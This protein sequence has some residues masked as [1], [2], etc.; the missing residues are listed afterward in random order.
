ML[1][2][3]DPQQF[4]D[5]RKAV[6]HAYWPE[7]AY[8]AQKSQ[9]PGSWSIGKH[10]DD[11]IETLKM[12]LFGKS[13]DDPLAIVEQV[14][15]SGKFY[16][17][18]NGAAKTK[19]VGCPFLGRFHRMYLK[20]WWTQPY[21][22]PQ[23]QAE[24]LFR[25]ER[26]KDGGNYSANK[27]NFYHFVNVVSALARLIIY[28]KNANNITGL[29]GNVEEFTS[30][31]FGGEP[32]LR[33]FKLMLAGFYHDIGKTVADPR[34]AVEGAIILG[35]HTTSA[36][37]QLHEIVG[38]YR[39]DY[40]FER[41]DLLYVAALVLYHDHFGTLGTGEDGYMALVNPEPKIILVDSTS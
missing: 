40:S 41:E 12:C 32:S 4:T 25:L 22:N 8:L 9:L 29:F 18:F 5:C 26:E 11:K 1:Y 31:V 33:T 24:E 14:N 19:E 16:K 3:I 37:Y 28:F 39:K 23:D 6:K 20:R 10:D 15:S 38:A 7:K 27:H 34:H 36:Q 13:E 2:H 21:D 35:Y 17:V 30:V